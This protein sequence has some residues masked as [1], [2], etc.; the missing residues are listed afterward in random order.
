ME[1]LTGVL[2]VV[3]TVNIGSVAVILTGNV[4]GTGPA[5]TYLIWDCVIMRPPVLLMHLPLL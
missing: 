3:V 4:T 1:L 5:T 2:V